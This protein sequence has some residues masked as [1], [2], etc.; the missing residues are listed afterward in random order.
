MSN[1]RLCICNA[2]CKYEKLSQTSQINR[3]EN[4]I[5][6]QK[7]TRKF[8]N[9]DFGLWREISMIRGRITGVAK[10]ITL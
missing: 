9:C 1:D 3:R 6:K 8:F 5:K 7:M 10:I 4:I 2:E